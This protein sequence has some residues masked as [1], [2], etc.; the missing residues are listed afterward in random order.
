MSTIVFLDTH[1]YLHYHDFD[2]I[3]WLKILRSE[4][5]VIVVP[6]VIVRELN[7]HKDTHYNPRIR[8]RAETALKKL[9]NLVGSPPHRAEIR[10]NV[11][12][13]LESRDPSIDFAQYNLVKE[14]NDD[15]LVASVLQSKEG[16]NSQRTVLVTADSG[17]TLVSKGSRLDIETY[18]LD[19]ALKLT[20]EA[21]PE[22]DKIREL[23][24]ELRE[25]KGRSPELI[26]S[27]GE[28]SQRISLN[29]NSPR[30]ADPDAVETTLR[31]LR[32]DNPKIELPERDISSE[33]NLTIR[34]ALEQGLWRQIPSADIEAYN[35]RLEEYFTA[36]RSYLEVTML[37]YEHLR[38]LSLRFQI[39]LQNTGTAP[40]SD[41]DISMH[42]PDGFR[43]GMASEFPRRPSPPKPPNKPNSLFDQLIRST[44]FP[45]VIMPRAL[46]PSDYPPSPPPNVSTPIIRKTHSYAV[47]LHVEYIKHQ[48]SEPLDALYIIFESPEDVQS[49]SIDYQ[50]LAADLPKRISG[51]LHV[52]VEHSKSNE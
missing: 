31:K 28:K 52:I 18:T 14:I 41:I 44:S 6:P 11:E 24:R 42:F 40:A 15:Q 12:V 16:A 34:E 33:S 38:S 29:L 22:Q 46:S 9:G 2:Q 35:S 37:E 8:K 10:K 20:S 30:L 5:V 17:L 48:T 1:V 36:Y 45:D 25:L 49:F 51:K 47:D 13:A 50:I 21:N 4:S 23:E 39:N 32:E 3:D 7:K 27:F 43:L 26:L 19:D